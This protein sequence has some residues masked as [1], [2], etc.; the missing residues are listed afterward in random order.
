[1][2]QGRH[3]H[4]IVRHATSENLPNEGV[5]D[6]N[7][8]TRGR[9]GSGTY[10]SGLQVDGC[11]VHL[12]YAWITEVP[13]PN[14]YVLEH[15]HPYDEM[16]FF[17]GGDSEDP[18]DLGAVVD[19]DLDG[20][21]YTIDTTSSVWIPAGLKHCPITYQRVDRPHGFIALSLDGRYRSGDYV[22]PDAT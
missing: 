16:L 17:M 14:P 19:L 18:A 12:H 22:T 5:L 11:A 2:T 8:E 13:G 10:L 4:L 3:E 15:D 20:E 1:M 6:Q 7:Q 21:T 9:S